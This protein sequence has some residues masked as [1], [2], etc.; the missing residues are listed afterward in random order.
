MNAK[1]LQ[2]TT[3]SSIPAPR[4][5]A[6]QHARS[7]WFRCA[8]TNAS[9]QRD[10][11]ASL[12]AAHR[13]AVLA[14]A[15]R[16]GAT[17]NDVEDVCADVFLVAL[18]RLAS[19]QGQS[20]PRTWLLGI[21]RRVLSDR[22]R[23]APHRREVLV[24]ACPEERSG[25][26]TEAEVLELERR[27]MLRAAV[28]ALPSPQRAVVTG[29]HLDEAPMADVARRAKVPL[30]TAYARLYAAHGQLRTRLATH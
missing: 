24:D 23:G 3:S 7:V 28:H 15:R 4:P 25:H 11:L 22:R 13:N 17:D 1:V 9:L 16:L 26:D 12:Y 14:F 29:Y 6:E 5:T 10:V 20:T 27:A 19:F 8:A 21:T 2:P 30:Q 18:K